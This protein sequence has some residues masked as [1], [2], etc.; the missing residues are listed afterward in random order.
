M[1]QKP[2]AVCTTAMIII[3]IAVFLILSV[4]G[5]TEDAVFML[6]HGAMY[7]P[8]LV[9][10]HEF[11]RIF[12]SMFMH[13]GISH[14]LNNMVLLGA[15][16][17]NLELE[18]GKIRFVISDLI[19]GIGGNMLSVYHGLSTET[20]AVSAGASGA[21]F[22]LMGAL[23]YVVIANKGRLGR[24]SGK[25][26]L[27]MVALSLYFGLTSSGVDNWAHIGGLISGFIMAVILYRRPKPYSPYFRPEV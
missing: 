25:G 18:A 22:G 19:S 14:L 8:I 5:N 12:T 9:Q 7:E 15:L 20:Y 2:E 13:F 11:Y 16:G 1:R 27:F 26:L 6:R 3:N 23:L 21:V 24:L 10:D 4:F 17:W